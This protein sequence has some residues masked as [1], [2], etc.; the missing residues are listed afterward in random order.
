MQKVSI[1]IP[2]IRPESAQRCIKAIKKNAGIDINQYEIVTGI[3]SDEVGCPKMVKRLVEKAKYNLVMFLGDDTVP[4][5]DFLKNALTAMESLPDGWG[6]VGLN[7][8][9]GNP[10]AHW[11]A[12]KRMLKYIDG[13]CF[14]STEY[15]HCWCDNELKDIADE[16]GR[17][18]FAEDAKIEHKHPINKSAD[19]DNGYA[20]AYSEEAKKHDQKTYFKRKIRRMKKKHDTRLAIAEPLTDE[21]V[22]S[23]FHFSSV[24]TISKYLIDL[25][26]N[27]N[28]VAVDFL[29]P[30]YPGQIDAVRN[31]LVKQALMLG[32]THVLF[33]DTDQIYSDSDMIKKMLDHNKQVV[34]A[35]VHRRYP[36][37]D[38]LLLRGDPGGLYSVPDDEIEAGGLVE[39]GATGCGCI[40]YDTEVFLNIDPPWFELTTGEFGQPVGE[41]VGFCE[42]LKAAGYKIYVDCSIDIKHL[43][44]LAVD[45]GTHKLYKKLKG[46]N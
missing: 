33:M 40:L 30:K 43:S 2:I 5:K 10:V 37:F 22:Y 15:K 32:C 18:K 29:S 34:G 11:M 12:D 36:P 45:W 3:D 7:T 20:K 44:L 42:K 35:K 14:F 17:W 21:K 25:F 1:I 16:L 26:K 46:V 8:E 23:H 6:V 41:D 24:R 13:G 9:P 19:W 4:Q 39:V 31:E 27:G 28:S 38:P